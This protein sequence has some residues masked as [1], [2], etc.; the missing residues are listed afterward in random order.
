MTLATNL[1]SGAGLPSSNTVPSLVANGPAKSDGV[2]SSPS[3]PSADKGNEL[4]R[5]LPFKFD[6]QATLQTLKGMYPEY[7]KAF[8]QIDKKDTVLFRRVW[9]VHEAIF[10]GVTG[11]T[12]DKVFKV[13]FPASPL[14]ANISNYGELEDALGEYK[15]KVQ[16]FAH[17]SKVAELAP[18]LR[19]F[20]LAGTRAVKA[21]PE[22][23]LTIPNPTPEDREKAFLTFLIKYAIEQKEHKDTTKGGTATPPTESPLS[24]T[25]KPFESRALQSIST[26]NV[27]SS[28]SALPLVQK[29]DILADSQPFKFNYEGTASALVQSYRDV[30]KYPDYVKAIEVIKPSTNALAVEGAT[31][32]KA[33]AIYTAI[34]PKDNDKLFAHLSTNFPKPPA[35]EKIDTAGK[36]A[37]ALTDYQERVHLYALEKGIGRESEPALRVSGLYGALMMG[38]EAPKIPLTIENPQPRDRDL[39]ALTFFLDYAIKQREL[40]AIIPPT[41]PFPSPCTDE[42][43]TPVTADYKYEAREILERIKSSSPNLYH[44]LN[45]SSSRNLSAADLRGEVLREVFGDSVAKEAINILAKNRGTFPAYPDGTAQRTY[46][47]LA[48]ADKAYASSVDKLVV[49][50]MLSQSATDSLPLLQAAVRSAGI[51]NQLPRIPGTESTFDCVVFAADYARDE[52]ENVDPTSRKLEK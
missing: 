50:A 10:P 4:H 33:A 29:S 17:D 5:A 21:T 6:Y 1:P 7:S 12:F 16:A 40:G 38:R 44:L 52:K 14:L 37:S 19:T 25:H 24:D 43:F 28:S 3:V 48:A 27:G 47:D 46:D 26:N 22:I 20:G 39:A 32:T 9:D 49:S 23:P 34:F 15:R 18:S 51:L 42:K 11:N 8:D 13:E 41:L 36:L 35:L 30:K 31:S 2:G 45:S